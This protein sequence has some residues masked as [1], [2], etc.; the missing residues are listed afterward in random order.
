VY[1]TGG[2]RLAGLER[3]MAEAVAAVP[4]PSPG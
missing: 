3:M 2:I 1:P 4:I